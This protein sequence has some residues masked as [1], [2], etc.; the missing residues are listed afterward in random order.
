MSGI[1]NK[2]FKKF[3]IIS[4]KDLKMKDVKHFNFCSNK[5][6]PV[7]FSL[8][9]EIRCTT[10]YCYLHLENLS[11]IIIYEDPSLCGL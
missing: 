6:Q 8:V 9:S 10:V 2:N 3:Y 1:L 4:E 5:W 11:E 7:F